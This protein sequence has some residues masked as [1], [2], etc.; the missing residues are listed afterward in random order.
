M[1]TEK[2]LDINME[3]DLEFKPDHIPNSLPPM[4]NKLCKCG[5]VGEISCPHDDRCENSMSNTLPEKLQKEIQ[6]KALEYRGDMHCVS[7]DGEESGYIAGA[8]EYAQYKVLHEQARDI[9]QSF[10]T[11][12]E[13]DNTVSASIYR[14]IKQF[15]ETK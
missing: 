11:D 4:S 12:L 15:L 13:L 10:V 14:E 5:K 8:T 1:P 3:S 7:C 2:Q 6:S 9:L